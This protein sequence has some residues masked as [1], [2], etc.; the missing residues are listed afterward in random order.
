MRQAGLKPKSH[1]SGVYWVRA[2]GS[3]RRGKSKETESEHDEDYHFLDKDKDGI[4]SFWE[5]ADPVVTWVG[6]IFVFGF[7]I[8]LE[9]S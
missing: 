1:S 5:I 2:T 8:W 7:L 4:V 9:I 3:A 6:V